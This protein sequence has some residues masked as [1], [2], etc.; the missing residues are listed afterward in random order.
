MRKK[1]SEKRPSPCCPSDTCVTAAPSRKGRVYGRGH[2]KGGSS[3]V[4]GAPARSAGVGVGPSCPGEPHLTSARSLQRE[5][6]LQLVFGSGGRVLLRA[7]V[8][9]F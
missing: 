8:L 4:D 3:A 9:L 1:G 2:S 5:R 7:F 6:V